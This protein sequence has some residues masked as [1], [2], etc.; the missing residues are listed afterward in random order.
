MELAQV[1]KDHT[2][3]KQWNKG[4]RKSWKA[5]GKKRLKSGNSEEF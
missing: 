1:L 3:C 2:D 5:A 4:D